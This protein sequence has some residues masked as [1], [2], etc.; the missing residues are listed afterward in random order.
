MRNIAILTCLFFLYSCK[1]KVNQFKSVE[2][3]RQ[4][5]EGKWIEKYSVN[6]GELIAVGKY[7]MGEKVGVWRTKFQNKLYQKEVFKNDL[8]KTKTYYPDGKIK[9][10]GQ[11]KTEISKNERHWYYFGD[12]KYYDEKGKL[13]YIKKFENGK[14]VDSISSAKMSK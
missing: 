7:K 4:L 10:K 12:W 6:E 13:L 8:I 14:K 9:E 3:K 11:S 5:R 2:N 1:T